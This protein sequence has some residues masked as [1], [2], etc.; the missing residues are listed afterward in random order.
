M[1]CV[2][3]HIFYLT[4]HVKN[5]TFTHYVSH[6]GFICAWI[7]L[8]CI[9]WLNQINTLIWWNW[10]FNFKWLYFTFM[11]CKHVGFCGISD[12]VKISCNIYYHGRFC[13]LNHQIYL[14]IRIS[15]RILFLW[16]HFIHWIHCNTVI[17]IK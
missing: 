13:Y 4:T 2:Q 9:N 10:S 1:M 17:L 3:E 16:C 8:Y 15:K 5:D 6:N 11:R 14:A 12:N 7:Q